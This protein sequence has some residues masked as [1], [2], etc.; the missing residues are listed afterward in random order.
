MRPTSAPDHYERLM[1]EIERAPK[2][3]WWEAKLDE[4]KMKIRWS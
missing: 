1:Q 4:W 2:K 3:S